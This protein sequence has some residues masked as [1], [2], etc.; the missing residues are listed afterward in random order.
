MRDNEFDDKIKEELARAEKI[1]SH[2]KKKEKKKNSER[3]QIARA[4]ALVTQLGLQMACCVVL[5]VLLGVFL[6]RL[7][8][9]TPLFI[10]I[11]SLLG[12]AAS[13]K[14]IYD[15]SKDWED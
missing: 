13:I 8:G 15:T 14:I 12:S 11:C 1:L 5:G 10:I 3:R 4:F 6:D 2:E 9:T 7:F